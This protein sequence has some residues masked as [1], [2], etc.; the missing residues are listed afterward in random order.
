M[1][2]VLIGNGVIIQHGGKDYFNANIIQRAIDNI[3]TGN[4]P[5]HLYP[6]ECAEFIVALQ[7]EHSAVLH[8][9]YDK[10]VYTTFDR[11]SLNDFKLRYDINYKYSFTE[12]GFEDYFLLFE[13]THNKLGI[14]NPDRF[15]NRGVL[16]RMFLDS[17]FNQGKIE[18]IYK[19]FSVGFINWLK[20]HNHIF[21]TNYD[22]NLDISTGL[23]VQHLHGSFNK[24]SESYNPNSFRN[25]L[26]DDLLNGEKMD[27]DYLHLYSTC[28]ISY[29]G[30]QKSF[31]MR[32]ASLANSAMDK[33]LKGYKENPEIR[34]EI[35]NWDENN[36]LIKRLKEAI[37]LKSENPKLKHGEDYPYDMLKSISGTLEIVGLS[38]NNDSHLFELILEN[39]NIGQIIFNYFDEQ[40]VI[41]ANRLFLTKNLLTQNVRDFW[42]DVNR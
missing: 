20:K 35:D 17:V 39:N 16:R 29:V 22:S 25:Q 4:F 5:S 31:A 42:A 33:F 1:K 9:E 34:K 32:Q 2:S 11:I 10:Y 3:R 24:L 28:L 14:N 7:K 41:D 13:L 40:E 18:L 30:D 37:H 15:N 36:V 38:P 6:K 26:K 23:S 12:I 19:Q 21:T 8:G 27:L